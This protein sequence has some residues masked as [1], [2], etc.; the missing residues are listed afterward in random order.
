M[1]RPAW[2]DTRAIIAG[3]AIAGASASLGAAV[4]VRDRVAKAEASLDKHEAVQSEQFSQIR[5]DLAAIKGK[6]GIVP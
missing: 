4:D 5:A 1:S 2:L 3:L 6:L